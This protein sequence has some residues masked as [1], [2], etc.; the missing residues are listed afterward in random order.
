MKPKLAGSVKVGGIVRNA[1]HPNGRPID[2]GPQMVEISRDGRRVYFTNSLYSAWDRLVLSARRARRSADVQRRSEWRIDARSGLHGRIRRGATAPIRFWL[3]GGDC[4]TDSSATRP[5]DGR[6]MSAAWRPELWLAVIALG[7]YHGLNPGY[8]LRPRRGLQRDVGEAR[9]GGV[10]D[11]PSA[12]ERPFPG[13]WP[14][15]VTPVRVRAFS[16]AYL[17]WRPPHGA[18]GGERAGAELVRRPAPYV[19]IP[20]RPRRGS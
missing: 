16:P 19:N 7:A 20:A 12:R 2:G 5:L 13:D 10:R 4:S 3:E 14:R 11:F 6:A 8:G 17:D 1:A 9:A 15:R 18:V